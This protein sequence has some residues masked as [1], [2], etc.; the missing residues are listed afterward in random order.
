MTALISLPGWTMT[1][2]EAEADKYRRIACPFA[3]KSR[4]C[5]HGACCYTVVALAS[6]PEPFHSGQTD[7]KNRITKVEKII[8]VQTHAQ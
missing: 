1:A 4:M 7:S 2:Y 6:V 8:Y 5:V 3:P